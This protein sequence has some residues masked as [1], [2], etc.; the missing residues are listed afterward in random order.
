MHNLF[1]PPPLRIIVNFIGN[2]VMFKKI[3]FV[4]F[5]FKK[6]SLFPYVTYNMF[7]AFIV[8]NTY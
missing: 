4:T 5:F 6:R 2:R 8:E 1:L 3:F 7:S